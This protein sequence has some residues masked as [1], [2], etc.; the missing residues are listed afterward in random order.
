MGISSWSCAL[1]TSSNLINFSISSR[2]KSRECSL[3]CVR[4]RWIVE[5]ILSF[6]KGAHW[7]G[8]KLLK[9]FA[10]VSILVTNIYQKL[11]QLTE[12]LFTIT[13]RFKSRPVGSSMNGWG[14]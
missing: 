14:V 6:F 10:I 3:D 2:L 11:L 5:R 12:F 4:E 9:I 13:E 7:P 8:K 1:F